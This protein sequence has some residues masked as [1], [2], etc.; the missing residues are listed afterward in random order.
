[1]A[2]VVAGWKSDRTIENP[3]AVT[4]QI[5][6]V[7]RRRCHQ[8][9]RRT[10]SC[11]HDAVPSVERNREHGAA[12][13]LEAVRF[14]LIVGPDL[15]R[16]A[17]FNNA[18]SLLIHITLGMARAGAWDPDHVPPPPAF[19]AEEQNEVSVPPHA[20]PTLEGH[21]LPPPHSDAAV[22]RYPLRLH[23]VVIR[24]V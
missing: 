10:R 17:P 20:V 16:A 3:V 2:A 6:H 13:P 4:E 7:R 23:V 5:H 14:L 21:V 12:L 22:N 15:V 19:G 24:R 9:E 11:V 18:L 8:D 1:F